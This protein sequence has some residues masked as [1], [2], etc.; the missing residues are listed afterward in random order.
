MPTYNHIFWDLDHTLW[1]F[2]KNSVAALE[3]VY[4][5]FQLAEKGVAAFEEFN[6]NYHKHND[7]YWDR[8]RKGFITRE[9]MRWKRMWVTMLDYKIADEQL[10]KDMGE[11]YLE[12]LPLQTFV[13]KGAL[14]ILEYAKSLGCQQHIITNGFEATQI[15]KMTN[16]NMLHY[17]NQII[18]SE[19]AMALKPHKEIYDF[20]LQAT[21][22]TVQN[23]IMVGDAIDVDIAGAMNINMD[24]AW[25]NPHKI[26]STTKR[27]FE[28]A[29]LLELKSILG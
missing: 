23:S 10:A 7:K 11:A 27:T 24:A 25:F 13:M 1:D 14:E 5:H 12:F 22:A 3:K 17:F 15:Q 21:G 16:S 4:V 19:K 28:V 26:A 8:F 29:E 20:A 2:E 6:I 18:C 9:V